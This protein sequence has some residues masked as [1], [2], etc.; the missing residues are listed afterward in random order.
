[1]AGTMIVLNLTL[2]FMILG[3]AVSFVVGIR[4]RFA[5]R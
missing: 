2:S 5:E 4:R 1:M 3:G